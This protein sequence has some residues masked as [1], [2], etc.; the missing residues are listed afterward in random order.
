MCN[1]KQI[2]KVDPLHCPHC[3][4]KNDDCAPYQVG[5]ACPNGH[6]ITADDL[7]QPE[8]DTRTSTLGTRCPKC[9]EP[10]D[11][12]QTFIKGDECPRCHHIM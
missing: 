4:F 2:T 12:C 6:E 10:N 1:T 5:D 3:G 7:Q 8:H 9:G 11:D